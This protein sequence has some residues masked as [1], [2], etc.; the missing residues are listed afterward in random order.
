[1][2]MVARRLL[3]LE[4]DGLRVMIGIPWSQHI[5]FLDD[6]SLRRAIRRELA[7]FIQQLG[8][9]P[10]AMLFAV[11]NEIPGSVIRWHGRLRVERFLRSLYED[12]KAARPESHRRHASEEPLEL[13]AEH[14]EREHVQKD[15]REIAVQE[16]VR[17]DLPRLK[18][19]GPARHAHRAERPQREVH[20]QYAVAH[21]VKDE[22]D[23]VDDEQRAGDSR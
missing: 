18:T 2:Q 5:A 22:H 11:G 3:P 7:S 4:D 9:H 17:D 6:R 15:M 8:D 21:L 10:A 19:R 14:V 12:A 16:T 23:D 20:R 13:A 1:M